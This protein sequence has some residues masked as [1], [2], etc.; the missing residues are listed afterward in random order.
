MNTDARISVGLPHHPKTT[1]LL[2]RLGPGGPW[3][4]VCLYLWAAGTRADGNL[5]G[6]TDEDIEI[7]A[8]WQG[9][10]GAFVAALLEVRFLDGQRGDYRI[11][12][13]AEHNP[14]AAGAPERSMA[15]KWAALCRQYGQAGAARKMPEY[16]GRMRGASDSLARRTEAQCDP[17][18]PS[19]SPSP[20]PTPSQELTLSDER[21][22]DG[23][24]SIPDCPHAEVVALY[25]EILPELRGVQAWTPTRQQLL[26]SRWREARSR[27]NL[28]WWREF[29][30]YVRGCPFLMG[31]A[32]PMPG[33]EPFQA[34]L[35][36]LVRPKNFCKVVE[37]AYETKQR[38]A[39]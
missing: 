21:V 8:S 18:A 24:P 10:E 38:R 28:K 25:H 22:I 32:E 5:A 19:P 36:W 35:E 15:A 29:F 23:K 16:A 33:R 12:D 34:D 17:G 3:G 9:D 7:A 39:G 20:S 30:E 4:L 26:R 1:K 31:Q 6:L 2:R 27:Q 13:W 37:G 11:H 14:W